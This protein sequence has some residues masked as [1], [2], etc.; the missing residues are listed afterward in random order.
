MR[1]QERLK[2]ENGKQGVEQGG[3]KKRKMKIEKKTEK[4]RRQMRQENK[5]EKERFESVKNGMKTKLQR[6]RKLFDIG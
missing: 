1:K 4:E 5:T 2:P 3:L 6:K